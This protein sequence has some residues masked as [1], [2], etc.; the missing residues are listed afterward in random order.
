M[1]L[2]VIRQSN[3]LQMEAKGTYRI[4]HSNIVGLN[5]RQNPKNGTY[6]E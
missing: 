1:G 2:L 6:A 3:A 4:R 5:A